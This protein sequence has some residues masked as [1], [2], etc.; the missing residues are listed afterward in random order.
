MLFEKEMF[1]KLEYKNLISN[2]TS[3]KARTGDFNYI[4]ISKIKHYLN[5]KKK[6]PFKIFALGPEIPWTGPNDGQ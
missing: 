5:I 6:S 4:N 1:A 2:F 3:Q